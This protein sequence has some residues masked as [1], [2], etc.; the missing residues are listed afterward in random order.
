VFCTLV[1]EMLKAWCHSYL[2][3]CC[4]IALMQWNITLSKQCPKI[5]EL[6]KNLFKW[7]TRRQ[8]QTVYFFALAIFFAKTLRSKIAYLSFIRRKFRSCAWKRF[9]YIFW[10]SATKHRIERRTRKFLLGNGRVGRTV[11]PIMATFNCFST[12]GD[13]TS[14]TVIVG[15]WFHISRCKLKKWNVFF[16]SHRV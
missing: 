13:R 11:C 1:K 4:I 8:F 6:N 7:W 9:R 2:G 12:S 10:S 5:S 14:C 3:T 16:L 15:I